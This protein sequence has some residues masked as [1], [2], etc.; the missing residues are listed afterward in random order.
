MYSYVAL[1]FHVTLVPLSS[2][3]I[4]LVLKILALVNWKNRGHFSFQKREAICTNCRHSLHCTWKKE[5]LN[6]YVVTLN[7]KHSFNTGGQSE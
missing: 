5:I 2:Q 1:Q 6:S 7:L 4:I 3:P